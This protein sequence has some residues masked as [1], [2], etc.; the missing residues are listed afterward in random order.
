MVWSY[1]FLVNISQLNHV[2]QQDQLGRLAARLPL[3]ILKA[4]SY[5]NLVSLLFVVLLTVVTLL[6]L[7]YG[8]G[9]GLAYAGLGLSSFLSLVG[10]SRVMGGVAANAVR[11]TKMVSMQFTN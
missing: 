4:N 6:A 7:H 5:G 3:N 11:L 10:V 1:A 2:H 8:G 9:I